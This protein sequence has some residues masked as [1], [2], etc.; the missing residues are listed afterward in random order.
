MPREIATHTLRIFDSAV[1]LFD[2]SFSFNFQEADLIPRL[3]RA[4]AVCLR[5]EMPGALGSVAQWPKFLIHSIIAASNDAND[6]Y[7]MA[8]TAQGLKINSMT[9]LEPDVATPAD[10]LTLDVGKYNFNLAL[11]AT[12]KF[13][14]DGVDVVSSNVAKIG[15]AGDRLFLTFTSG[16][17]Y[18]YE[19]ASSQIYNDLLK[20]ESVGS[21]IR[22]TVV[23]VLPCSILIPEA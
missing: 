19:G 4:L 21:L 6:P 16:H 2:V 5:T 12:E 8:L 13:P 14:S 18:V 1:P 17:T 23:N 22:K 10:A 11:Y 20:A 9:T 15:M 3:T 7:A